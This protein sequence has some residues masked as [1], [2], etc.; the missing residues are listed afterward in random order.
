VLPTIDDHKLIDL[1]IL[2]FH[3][4]HVRFRDG[5]QPALPRKSLFGKT[6]K[7]DLNVR[8]LLWQGEGNGYRV[9]PGKRMG[10]IPFRC[11][12]DS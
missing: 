12:E 4:G 7:G 9:P 6:G 10:K 11:A 5:N 3:S 1:P 2:L 8:L